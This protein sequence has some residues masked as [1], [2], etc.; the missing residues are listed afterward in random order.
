MDGIR[1]REIEWLQVG[2]WVPKPSWLPEGCNMPKVANTSFD[3]AFQLVRMVTHMG[4]LASGPV[5]AMAYRL[6]LGLP[7]LSSLL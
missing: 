1:D 7:S 3:T 4:G 6:M 5:V 2:Y